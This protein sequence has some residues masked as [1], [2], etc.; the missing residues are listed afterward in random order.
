MSAAAKIFPITVDPAGEYNAQQGVVQTPEPI[1]TKG[2]AMKDAFYFSHDANASSDPKISAMIGR[3][4]IEGYGRFWI[5]VEMM[6]DAPGYK[7][8]VDE[9]MWDALAMRLRCTPEAA[10]TYVE[11]CVQRYKLFNSDGAYLWSESL[12][13]RMA[14][15][16]E[17]RREFSEAGK[18][19]AA[20]RWEK[21]HRETE[22]KNRGA[23]A[24]P[25]KTDGKESKGKKSKELI[26]S[27]SCSELDKQAPEPPA[28]PPDDRSL[29][30]VIRMPLVGDAEYPVTRARVDE[31]E[32]AYPAVDVE[33]GLRNMRQWCLSKP[34]RR[35][36]MRGVAAFIT[37]WLS[38]DQ[39]SGKNLRRTER[40]ATPQVGNSHYPQYP[41]K[42]L[43][44]SQAGILATERNQP[45]YVT[46]WPRFRGRDK[47]LY[48]Q[49]PDHLGRPVPEGFIPW[50]AA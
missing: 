18:R 49:H 36:T 9:C 11:D 1:A 5:L 50:E 48:F 31:L 14:M 45:N 22:Q 29:E 19:G 21:K 27:E 15:R 13:R 17:A 2:S 43:P 4:G 40:S 37:N 42:M 32:T 16:E 34:N 23:M 35:K 44:A 6:R 7:L 8:P 26:P 25:S 39:D 28:T 3:Y 33:Q 20:R 41:A 12:R 24:T 30:V 46:T 38:K 47:K 10:K